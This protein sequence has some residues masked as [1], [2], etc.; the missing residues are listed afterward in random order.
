MHRDPDR[1]SVKR[2][3][4]CLTLIGLA[5][6][7]SGVG[8]IIH[9]LAWGTESGSGKL[10]L[11]A[12][13]AGGLP[14]ALFG[15]AIMFGRSV[16]DIDSRSRTITK[17]WGVLVPFKS[18]TIS[19]D[20]MR[21]VSISREKRRS[22]DSSV[23]VFPVRIEGKRGAID[24]HQLGEYADARRRAEEVAKFLHFGIEDTTTGKRII[25]EAETLDMS[26]RDKAQASG[27]P[28][29]RPGEQPA[30]S[31]VAVT[32]D[33]SEATFD[34][35]ASGLGIVAFLGMGVGLLLL[36]APFV[37]LFAIKSPTE[38]L[39]EV[40]KV[41]PVLALFGLIWVCGMLGFIVMIIKGSTARVRVII[42]PRELKVET[43]SFM[44]TKTETI[45]AD[46]LEEL[47]LVGRRA[48]G[49]PELWR[50]FVGS[51]ERLVALADRA[52]IEF[53]R[54]LSRAE[55]KWLGDT[56]RFIVTS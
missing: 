45:P 10:P 23:T 37:I 29:A 13:I 27:E 41:W 50:L 31:R 19:F 52:Q 56:I 55:L 6:F 22:G 17:W 15:F 48:S 38:V 46:E 32:S 3:G 34:M 26:L 36:C 9:A 53:G 40:G 43:R 4:G 42:D 28:T 20:E 33:G 2:G 7:L 1:Y 5:V 18:T 30:G 21:A 24:T 35:P 54:G 39:K 11:S 12:A 8:P 25:R 49:P 44:G 47:D 51:N 16:V 14:M